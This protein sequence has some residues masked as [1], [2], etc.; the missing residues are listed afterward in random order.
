MSCIEPVK[1]TFPHLVDMGNELLGA[2]EIK[3]AERTHV[4][5]AVIRPV[6]A[7]LGNIRRH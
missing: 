5:A 3:R 4:A 7:L 6:F 2:A 1:V